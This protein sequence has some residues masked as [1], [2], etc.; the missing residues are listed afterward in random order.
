M[1]MELLDELVRCVSSTMPVN[2]GVERE[3]ALSYRVLHSAQSDRPSFTSRKDVDSLRSER[4]EQRI[5]A[6]SDEIFR[7]HLLEGIVQFVTNSLRAAD[8]ACSL[9]SFKDMKTLSAMA[10]LVEWIQTLFLPLFRDRLPASMRSY[11]LDA[12]FQVTVNRN[13]RPSE[14]DRQRQRI[15]A[16]LGAAAAAPSMLNAA[17][18]QKSCSPPSMLTAARHQK[19]G[20]PA[21]VSD[22]SAFQHMRNR[23]EK[24]ATECKAQRM[25]LVCN[26]GAMCCKPCYG[27]KSTDG[28]A[29]SYQC[30]ACREE[31]KGTTAAVRPRQVHFCSTCRLDFQPLDI[32][33]WCPEC[34]C[35][36]CPRCAAVAQSERLRRAVKR[37]SDEAP[38]HGGASGV[39]TLLC[40]ICVGS[41]VYE[42]GRGAVCKGLFHKILGGRS[43]QQTNWAELTR[44][45]LQ[46]TTSKL[47]ADELGDL[48]YDLFFNGHRDVFAEYLPPFLELVVAQLRCSVVPSVDPFHLLYYTGGHPMASTYLLAKV[49]RAQ[50]EDALRKSEKLVLQEARVLASE[51][52][53][54]LRVGIFG[55]DVVMNSPT[56]DLVHPVLEYWR[57]CKAAERY[58]FFLFADGPVD[59]T[60][61]TAS[62]I[63][64]LFEG[65]LVLFDETMT[66]RTKYSMFDETNLHVLVTLTGWTHGHIAEVIAALGR[67]PS[68]VAVF[69][70]LGFAAPLM[71]M[72]E[73]VHWTIVGSHA[74]SSRQKLESAALRERVAVVSCY[75]P[76]QGHL[77][78]PNHSRTWTRK[79]FNLPSSDDHFIYFF[80][81]STNRLVEEILIMWLEIVSRVE[82]SCLLLL[83]KPHGM[84]RRIK[85]WIRKYI[86]TVKPN[87]NPHRVLWRPFQ[88]K[89]HF[90]GLIQATVENGAG[91]C[92]DSVKPIGLHTSAGD[93]FGNGAVVLSWSCDEGFQ[94][95]VAAELAA[96]LG[97][98][99]QLVAPSCAEFPALAVRFAQNRPLQRAM[100]KY[101]RQAWAKRVEEALL[102]RQVLQVLEEGVTMFVNAGRDYKKLQDIDV[103]QGLPP[104]QL[105]AASPEYEA[106]AAAEAGPEATKRKELLAQMRAAD[107]PLQE[108][109]GTHALK[110]LEEH[111]RKGL[112]L[113][114]VVGAGAFSIVISATAE[115]TINAFV[116]KG[117]RVALKLSREGVSADHVRNCSLAREAMNTTL[118]ETR[119]QH[120]EF[121]DIIPEPVYVWDSR[122]AGR[123]FFGHT[124]PDEAGQ[125]MVFE[126]VELI[127]ECFGDVI[128]RYGEEWRQNGVLDE[129]F[130]YMVLRPMFQLAHELRQT[131]GL[132][133]MDF[134][135]A[136]VGRRENGRLAV[137]D[138]GSAI[139][140]PL[141]RDNE[142]RANSLPVHLSQNLPEGQIVPPEKAQGRKL[143]G[144]RDP[145]SCLLVIS[146][147]KVSDYCVALT[148][149]GRGLG[150]IG[151]ATMGY[152]D[153]AFRFGKGQRIEPDEAYPYD[154]FALG[155]TVSKLLRYIRRKQSLEDWDRSA[156]QAAREGPEGIKRLML[157]AVDPRARDQ[158]TQH[159]TV[160]RVSSLLAAVLNPDPKARMGAQN[161]MLHPANT[162]PFFSPQHSLALVDGQG[163]AM[164]GGP[165]ESLPVPFRTHPGLKGVTLPPVDLMPQPDMGTGVK[166]RRFLRKG[167]VAAVYGGEFIP[168]VDTG[169]LR[170]VY[171][172]RFMVTV[173]SAAN[174]PEDVF[175]CDAAPNAERPVVWFIDNNVAGPFMNG[176]DGD[177]PDVNCTLDRHSA[178]KDEAGRVW[179]LLRANRD[180]SEGEWLMWKY[181][182][183]A[184]AGLSGQGAAYTFD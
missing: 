57:T 136:N 129:S 39:I 36:F 112:T 176:R 157:D 35:R 68:P 109:M 41:E 151:G 78:H 60:H 98:F 27:L 13:L 76:S 71:Y 46:K 43:V 20:Q 183:R 168:G 143:Q 97:L 50:A 161:A 163:I 142:R 130:Q 6:K 25:R 184:G 110:I 32:Q 150:R 31:R 38:V 147:Q 141:P 9:S 66:P 37:S 166:L 117:T 91:A 169:R 73:A 133:V 28:N 170:S 174:I 139:V 180:I 42:A 92:L 134:K 2:T 164:A 118:L 7:T 69:N 108:R 146:N 84:R 122:K 156:C 154:M 149:K 45:Q 106:V 135:P 144:T 172:S 107:L 125:C 22:F 175:I 33:S 70:W 114:S 81:A 14:K 104:V 140:L 167:W 177:G 88:S 96:D 121:G 54:V 148:E 145:S 58:E 30:D 124:P 23:C 52:P 59:D 178:W 16:S 137:W 153:Q 173:R 82:G 21:R 102:A 75:Q 101:V 89:T 47:P 94:T 24:C 64:N 120:K 3:L 128:K 72:P 44:D 62:A 87:F 86:A 171:A 18:H 74:L 83:S 12:E 158:M 116:P 15:P 65:R 49:C 90:C 17:R 127:D 40:P 1:T 162:L 56:A 61:P 8:L 115:Q 11:F 152:A 4:S 131:A 10:Q 5:R 132:A 63:A 67:G 179:F 99:D 34:H 119:L 55:S 77:S 95:R 53:A 105:F 93:A 181:D 26:C 182:W 123:C 165:V 51:R 80:P 103:T 155:R 126:C 160:E 48:L 85:H 138:L 19:S 29:I 111:Q 113:H 100:Q 159:I 79:H